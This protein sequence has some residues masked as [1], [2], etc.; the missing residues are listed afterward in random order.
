MLSLKAKNL[1]AAAHGFFG[2]EG[3]VSEGLF[4]SLNCG[5]GSGDDLAAVAT[6][7]E[8]VRE[9]L[10]AAHLVTP[11][12]MHSPDAVIVNAPWDMGKGPQADAMASATP[13]IALGIL[14]A[15]CTPVLLADAEAGVIGAAHAGWKGALGG[16]I[17]SV[18][19]AMESLG[20][21]RG[22]IAAA[23]GPC[24]HAG[25]YE[26]GSEF[27]ARFMKAAAANEHFFRG[28]PP[29]G[30]LELAR[31]PFG[32]RPVTT[33][34][35]KDNPL[36]LEGLLH[37][38]ERQQRP[39]YRITKKG[40]KR[41]LELKRLTGHWSF[42]LEG[43]VVHRLRQAKIKDISRIFR[44]TYSHEAD[45]FSFRRATHRGENAYG[46]QISAIVLR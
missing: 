44:D 36:F 23:V 22:R 34:D 39:V 41:L 1:P 8:R 7:R 13:G 24:I 31:H 6:N 32:L 35:I 17:E 29:I 28:R 9:S 5:P 10:A 43:Y 15:D 30:F 40:M 3:G 21:R 37:R 45:Y 20:A 27:R 26:V 25:S 46:R 38:D 16:V 42:D 4:A 33:D 19:V 14:T 18:V 11:Y 2:R 12:Q